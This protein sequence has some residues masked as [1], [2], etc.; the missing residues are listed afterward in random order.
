MVAQS[1]APVL[2]SGESG[3]GKELVA[4]M[5]HEASSRAKG[6]FVVVNCGALAENL[7]EAE[8]FG[9]E[10]GAFT[11]AVKKRDGRFKAA[12][13]GTLF[14]D[15]IGELPPLAQTKLL[16]V[17]QEGTF[18]PIG[19]NLTVKV[20][21]RIVSATHRNLRDLTKT[22]AFRE[23]LYY[24]INVI[25]I[26]LPPLRER[27]GD[28]PLLLRYLLERFSPK[29]AA[30]P[31]L[32]P[33][34]WAAL[35]QYGFPGNVREFQH[36][37]EHATVLSGGQS[38]DVEHL[39]V[40]ILDSVQPRASQLPNSA[41]AGGAELQPLQLAVRAFE[42]QYLQRALEATGGKRAKAA[43]LM[44]IARKTFWEKMR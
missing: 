4:R 38:I 30:M 1:E 21:V 32:T 16:R 3:T 39:P 7:I 23:D 13:G 8:L 36:A 25:E 12:D 9:H 14:L 24:R 20:D 27:P 35:K 28:L 33:A 6:P 31:T 11:G 40:S 43:D 22:L 2:I 17:L 19:T 29:G 41:A 10:R 34:A 18:E 5:I 26:P 44:G 42:R 15:E 37:I